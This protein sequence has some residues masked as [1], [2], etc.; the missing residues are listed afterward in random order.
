MQVIISNEENE[1][2]YISFRTAVESQFFK[3]SWYKQIGLSYSKVRI[4]QGKSRKVSSNYR[5]FWKT[6][7]SRIQDSTVMK[8]ICFK[9]KTFIFYFFLDLH[10]YH[11]W[12]KDVYQ[13]HA[14]LCHNH[15]RFSIGS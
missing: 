15:F 6:K 8:K 5:E 1:F 4:I 9:I 12:P 10:I 2:T 7:H 3:P 11:S 13:S 14:L